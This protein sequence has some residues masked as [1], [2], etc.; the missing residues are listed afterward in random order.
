MRIFA[1]N[2]VFMFLFIKSHPVVEATLAALVT[3]GMLLSL[4]VVFEPLASRAATTTDQFTVSQTIN[5]EISFSTTATDVTMVGSLNG[6]TGGMSTGTTQVIVK[7]NNALGYN[8]TISF[9]SSSYGTAA[10]NRNGGG[11]D[12]EDYTPASAGVPDFTFGTETFGQLAYTISASTT[13][14]LDQTFRNNGSACNNNS[15]GDV[16]A[17]CWYNP[18]TTAE[19]I[20]NRT[21]ATSASG[22]GTMVH[23]RVHIPNN[24]TPAIPSGTYTAT[25]TLTAVTN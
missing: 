1:N 7:T 20:V 3:V 9:A 14:D 8:M 2:L 22:E 25:A 21:T 23:F 17:S 6:L 24:P 18:S 13:A 15:G 11:G 19:T 12:I 16:V 4:Y 10:M 5:N